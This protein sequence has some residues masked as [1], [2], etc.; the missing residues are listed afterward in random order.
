MSPSQRGETFPFRDF[1]SPALSS[2]KPRIGG[3]ARADGAQWHR[4]NSKIPQKQRAESLWAIP[5]EVLDSIRWIGI[6]FSWFLGAPVTAISF[7]ASLGTFSFSHAILLFHTKE[8]EFHLSFIRWIMDKR[9]AVL[10]CVV[11]LSL[12]KQ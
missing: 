10:P 5:L 2:S 3:K 6:C 9:R 7:K 1:P 4:T 8:V 12:S 11:K